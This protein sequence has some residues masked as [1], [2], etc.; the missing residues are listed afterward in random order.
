MEQRFSEMTPYELTQKIGEFTD[1]ARKA[2]QMG[3]INE[4]AVYERKIDMARAYLMDPES[5]RPGQ[6]YYVDDRAFRIDYMKGNFAWGR[7]EDSEKMHGVPISLLKKAKRQ[8]V[9]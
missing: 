8:R 2:E 4:L 7:F 6:L 3:M 9:E 1:K 5:F